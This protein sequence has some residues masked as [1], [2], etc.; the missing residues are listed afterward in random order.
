MRKC[1]EEI[2]IFKIS[3][4]IGKGPQILSCLLIKKDL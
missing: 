2:I 3:N 1:S 4:N